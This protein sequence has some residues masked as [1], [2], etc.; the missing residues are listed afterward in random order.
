MNYTPGPW[1]WCTSNSFLRLSS[2]ATGKDGGVI[3]SYVMRDGHPSLRVSKEDMDLIAAA[4]D[5][6]EALQL[7]EKAMAKG[8]NVTYPEWYGVINKARAA[9]S[10]ALG[11]E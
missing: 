1:Q 7:A 5:L 3:D 11:E 9:I 4:P 8:R 6:L 10:K 2:Q